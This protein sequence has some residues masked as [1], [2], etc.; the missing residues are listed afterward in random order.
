[1]AKT[2]AKAKSNSIYSTLST[3]IKFRWAI[4]HG[5]TSRK[6]GRNVLSF[7][8]AVIAQSF[9]LEGLLHILN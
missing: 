2:K 8:G 9:V 3:Q 6:T 5:T 1:M 4:G 7:T